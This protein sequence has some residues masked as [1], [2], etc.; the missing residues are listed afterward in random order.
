MKRTL[1]ILLAV[2]GVLVALIVVAVIALPLIFDP[3]DYKPQINA[4]IER[5]IGREVNI[6]GDIG[7]SVFPW[8]GLELGRVEVANAEGFGDKPMAEMNSA[9]VSVKL[10][11]LIQRDIEVGTVTLNGLRLRLARNAD[12]RSNWADISEHLSEGQAEAEEAEQTEA[13]DDVDTGTQTEGGFTLE[14]L[15][16]GAIDVS[17][18]AISWRDETTGA[19]YRLT[20]VRLGTGRLV[21]GQPVRLEF[22]GDLAAPEEDLAADFNLVARVEPNIADQFYRFS[23]M[24]L[25]VL[26]TGE[27]V[28]NGKQQASLSGNG[29]YDAAEGRLK[30][31]GMTFQGAGL[32]VTAN[33]DGIGLND[34]PAY[35]GRVTF[36]RFDPRAVMNELGMDAPATQKSGALSSAGFDAQFDIN[37]DRAEFK[38]ILATLDESSLKGSARVE[39]FERP[40]FKFD[41]DLDQL[42]VDDYLPPGSAE[43]AQSEQPAETGGGEKQKAAEI[44][45]S[46]LKDLRLNGQLSAGSLTAANIEVTHAELTVAARDGVLTIEPLTADLYD[47]NVRVSARVDA[48]RDTPRYAFKGNLNGLQ[49]EPLLKDVADTDRVAALANMSVDVTSAGKQVASMKRALNGNLSFDLRDGAF[50]GFNLAEVIAAARTRLAGDEVGSDD[51]GIGSDE[52]TPFNRFAASFSISDGVLAGKDLNLV[53]RVLQATGSGSY[54][55]ADNKLDYTV[56]AMVPEDSSGKLADLAGLQVP[57]KLTGNL[58]SPDYSLDVKTALRGAAEKRLQEESDDLK[59]KVREKLE[60]RGKKVDADTRARIEKGLNSLLGGSSKKAAADD[61][62]DSASTPAAPAEQGEGGDAGVEAENRAGENNEAAAQENA[63]SPAQ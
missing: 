26:A 15:Q 59:N 35:A 17:D 31:S 30:L 46:A 44:D 14:S 48:S 37:N 42:N 6:S 50:N 27:G 22:S 56:A 34:K 24:T 40:A 41:L 9:E 28:P 13:P 1:R 58:L 47:G 12:G 23:D 11:P 18:A 49:F 38:Q 60:E 54:D 21:D 36:K 63:Q 61:G 32:N 33:V 53:T 8:L 43:Q 39:N 52:Q 19:D 20:G 25:S 10:L 55:L 3:N 51:G 45:L 5:Q 57:I 62:T 29:E 2:L 4:A 7:L 16:I